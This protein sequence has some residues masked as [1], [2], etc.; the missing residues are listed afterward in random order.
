MLG[1]SLGQFFKQYLEPIKLNEVQVDWK[2]IDL[3]YLLEDKY[4]IH[5]ANNIKKAKPVSGA[6]IVQ[7]AHNIDGD[8]RIKYKDQWDFENIAQQFG[9]FQEW[10][11]GVPRAAYKGVVVFRYQT[12]RRIFLVG[13]ESLKL[14][15]IEDLDS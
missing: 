7:K 1:S 12:T 14:L 3:S 11:D 6:D 2:S 4:A 9:I 13:P 10:K 5:F 15:Q 8:V